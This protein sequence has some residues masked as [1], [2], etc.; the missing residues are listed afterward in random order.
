M[1]EEQP[2]RPG[3]TDRK[4]MPHFPEP[5]GPGK[6][7]KISNHCR[8]PDVDMG[9]G[10]FCH[11]TNR[12]GMGGTGDGQSPPGRTIQSSDS[13]T[14]LPDGGTNWS[15]ARLRRVRV[16]PS[17]LPAISKRRAICQA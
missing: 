15:L 1:P 17:R 2:V 8:G 10:F 11:G 13:C 7:R 6:L 9:L 5:A 16:K 4:R 12:F 14:P 3:K